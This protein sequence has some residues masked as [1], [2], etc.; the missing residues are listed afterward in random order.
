MSMKTSEFPN[1]CRK[2]IKKN[3][4]IN[5]GEGRERPAVAG[6]FSALM[7]GFWWRG[8]ISRGRS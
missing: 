6:E 1:L 2:K 5:G 7:G 4:K 3:K 8:G